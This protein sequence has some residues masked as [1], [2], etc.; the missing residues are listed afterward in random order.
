MVLLTAAM[1]VAAMAIVLPPLHTTRGVLPHLLVFGWPPALLVARICWALRQGAIRRRI[2]TTLDLFG[3]EKRRWALAIR[4]PEIVR[5]SETPERFQLYV[6]F[7][8]GITAVVFLM[9]VGGA[10]A[11]L[12]RL[13]GGASGLSEP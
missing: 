7:E 2:T 3:Q 11:P 4:D 10:F 13:I 8:L 1:I 9:F 6:L 5:L 12:L